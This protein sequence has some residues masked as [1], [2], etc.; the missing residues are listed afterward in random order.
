MGKNLGTERIADSYTRLV[1]IDTD[2]DNNVCDGE[3]NHILVTSH[4]NI[5]FSGSLSCA[6]G[7]LFHGNSN[8]QNIDGCKAEASLET[9]SMQ[10]GDRLQNFE[11]L[12]ISASGRPSVNHQG[13]AVKLV[14]GSF[15]GQTIYICND[16]RSYDANGN[17]NYKTGIL[18]IE[19]CLLQAPGAQGN[20]PLSM[21]AG[22]TA[23]FIWNDVNW[24]PIGGIS[25][26]GFIS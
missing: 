11:V 1:Q 22:S 5:F 8:V 7:S 20:L 2:N 6:S 19:K 18:G 14:S 17:S 25:G 24:M 4:R 13:S 12:R 21:S 15:W 3:G 23:G 16:D 10:G 26:S 9:I